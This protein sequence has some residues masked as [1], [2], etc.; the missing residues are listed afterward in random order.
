MKRLEVYVPD[1]YWEALKVMAD[2][3]N[4]FISNIIVNAIVKL[5]EVAEIALERRR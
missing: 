1:E 5:D 4:V 3:D 2:K